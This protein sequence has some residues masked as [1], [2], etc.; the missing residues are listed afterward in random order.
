MKESEAAMIGLGWSAPIEPVDAGTARR[1]ILWQHAQI[2]VFLE[3]ARTVAD[4]ALDG[5]ASPPDAVASAI[6]DLRSMM[7]VHLTF[8]E[9]VLIP[10]FNVDFPVGPRRVA[11]LLDEHKRQR[12]V[13]ADLHLEARNYPLLPTLA[14]KLAFLTSWLLTEMLEEERSMKVRDDDVSEKPDGAPG[15]GHGL[16]E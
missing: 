1:G 11:L 13:L 7:E 16:A 12:G 10:L 9:K 2:R 4:L 8:E 15:G 5:E 14:A 6:G 3:K